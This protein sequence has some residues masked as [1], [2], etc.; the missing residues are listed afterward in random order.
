MTRSEFYTH[1][2][3]LYLDQLHAESLTDEI[4]AA[5]AMAGA[6]DSDDSTGVAVAAGRQRLAQADDEW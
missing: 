6:V 3:Q 5:L 2:A 4:D 1:A